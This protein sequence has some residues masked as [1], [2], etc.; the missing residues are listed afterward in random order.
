LAAAWLGG[1]IFIRGEVPRE[2][3][4]YGFDPKRLRRYL[5]VVRRERGS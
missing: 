2:R 1:T 3:I 4:G 5:E